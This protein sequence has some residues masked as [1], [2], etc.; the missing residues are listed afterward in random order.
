MTI[1]WLAW[2]A[3]A[4]S[5]ITTAGL[6]AGWVWQASKISARSETN[7]ETAA[8]AVAAASE[9][10]AEAIKV[11][12][13]VAQLELKMAKDFASSEHLDKVENRLAVVIG[14]L[15]KEIRELRTIFMDRNNKI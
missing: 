8:A 14:D 15:A 12:R 3:I 11:S 1:D 7:K 9:A 4:M 6:V 5:A 10:R 13:E 2:A